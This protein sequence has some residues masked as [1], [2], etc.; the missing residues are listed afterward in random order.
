MAVAG[1]YVYVASADSSAVAIF[2][3]NPSTGALHQLAGRAGCVSETGQDGCTKGRGLADAL[4]LAISPDGRN[5]YV[6]AAYDVAEF[7]R[8]PETGRLTQLAGPNGCIAEFIGDGCGPGRALSVVASLA[9]SPDGRNVYVASFGSNAVVALSRDPSNGAL[10]EAPGLSGCTNE[11]G[12]EG[13]QQ[14]KALLQAFSVVVSPNGKFVYVGSILSSAI[15]S[16][17]RESDG[18]LRQI[19][20]PGECT[21]EGGS[22]GCATG[23]GLNGVAGVAVSPGGGYLYSGASGSSAVAA[24]FLTPTSGGLDQLKGPYGCAAE[25]GVEGCATAQGLAGAGPLAVS[26][27]G[28]SLYVGGLNSLAA[29]GRELSNG[30]I[31]QL[32]GSQAC[33]SEGRSHDAC[34]AGRGLAGVS[35]V[36]V[37][38][39]GRSVYVVSAPS[40][41]NGTVAVFA[42]VPGPIN[43]RVRFTGAPRRCVSAPF[44]I[45]VA[46]TG[47]LPIRSLRLELDGRVVAHSGQ[48][49]LTHLVDVRR[50]KRPSHTLTAR[51]TDLAGDT[52][53]VSSRFRRC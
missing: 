2:R 45:S 14:G 25:H 15:M 3:R 32:P 35:S 48:S 36:A 5:L 24:L 1:N 39:D 27:D 22:E 42:R 30:R 21:S 18:S 12:G 16:F 34:A 28:R 44:T 11:D 4:S 9:V 19:P 6:A 31:D 17:E 26:P 46:G 33:F 41:R 52:R 50:L 8:H 47:T 43:L 49:Q 23:R 29:F 10:S 40:K 7:K 51:A 13:C 20:S 53:R 38:P 37:S